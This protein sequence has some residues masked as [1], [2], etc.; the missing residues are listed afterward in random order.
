MKSQL[1]LGARREVGTVG[2]VAGMCG[3]YAS[4]LMTAAN[5]VT[6]DAQ[7]AGSGNAVGVVLSAVATVFIAV[8]VYVAAVVIANG[9]DTVVAGRLR[10]IAVLRLLGA[11]ARSLR[12]SIVR[13][14]TSVAAVGAV[15][16]VLAGALVGDVV[17]IGPGE[18]RQPARGGLRVAAAA[19]GGRGAG[20]HRERRRGLV[21]RVSGGAAGHALRRRCW[22]HRCRRPRHAGSA[23]S[24]GSRL[25]G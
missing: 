25:S 12:R 18:P 16:G 14:A 3:F 20:H 8:A 17:R 6:V 15:V 22:V 13:G 4:V 10:Q 5:L 2:L 21:D 24:G 9:V 19:L 11:D 1:V 7:S 23:G